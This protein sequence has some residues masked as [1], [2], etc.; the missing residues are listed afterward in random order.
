MR[1]SSGGTPGRR[2]DGGGGSSVRCL[3]RMAN[4]VSATKGRRAGQR[5]V[6]DDAQRVEVAA[7]VRPLGLDRLR[8]HVFGAA[9]EG[10]GD[11]E[12]VE[13][14]RPRDAVVHDLDRPVRQDHHVRGL[15][16]PVHDTLE[17][18]VVQG[19]RHLHHGLR[20]RA[21]VERPLA[22]EARLQ[23]LAG[24]ELHREVGDALHFAH[25]RGCG[26]CSGDGGCGR[27]PP[28]AGSAR[29][30]PALPG[31]RA[32]GASARRPRSPLGA[33]DGGHSPAA[34]RAE[35]VIVA[36]VLAAVRAAVRAGVGQS[37]G[38]APGRRGGGGIEGPAGPRSWGTRCAA[39]SDGGGPR[40]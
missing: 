9:Q 30:T 2:R 29:G 26:R 20:G 28:R 24:H 10:A 31:T 27:S 4:G 40:R 13:A 1:S 6:E 32:G 5:L 35:E 25:A 22:L 11:G 19:L 16:V 36:E 7:R 3:C 39:G 37:G 17:V 34:E 8:G 38:R 33:E 18:R 15:Q 12:P 21:R 14:P 23:R